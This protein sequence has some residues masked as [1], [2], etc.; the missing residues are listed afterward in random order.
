MRP[1]KTSPVPPVARPGFPVGLRKS[2]PSGV[3][4]TVRWPLRTATAP[5]AR[6]R[7]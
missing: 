5:L 3:A 2:R 7:S 1:V 4:V 6:A